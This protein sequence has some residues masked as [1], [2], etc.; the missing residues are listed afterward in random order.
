MQY[1]GPDGDLFTQQQNLMRPIQEEVLTAIE[2][3]ARRE[4]YDYVFDKGG[5][6]LFMYAEE[7]FDLSDQVLSELGIDVET[8][9]GQGAR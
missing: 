2:E 8:N 9:G 4:G 6:Y 3:V 1:F 7:E 5:D